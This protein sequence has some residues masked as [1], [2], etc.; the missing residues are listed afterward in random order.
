MQSQAA[1]GLIR[2]YQLRAEQEEAT[3]ILIF[4]SRSTPIFPQREAGRT[5]PPLAAANLAVPL[6]LLGAFGAVRAW[7]RKRRYAEF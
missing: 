5:A 4:P 3:Q 1:A 7:R 2:D 6:V